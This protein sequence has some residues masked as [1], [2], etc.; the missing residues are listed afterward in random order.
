MMTPEHLLA[1]T[2]EIEVL[3]RLIMCEGVRAGGQG[4]LSPLPEELNDFLTL[5]LLV[6]CRHR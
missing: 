3:Y 5:N 4:G 6:I 2:E 1:W